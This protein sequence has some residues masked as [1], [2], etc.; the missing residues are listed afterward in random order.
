[1]LKVSTYLV[2]LVQIQSFSKF[3][4]PVS[5]LQRFVQAAKLVYTQQIFGI[6]GAGKYGCHKNEVQAEHVA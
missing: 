5:C 6:R 4:W 3:D 2:V 1:M